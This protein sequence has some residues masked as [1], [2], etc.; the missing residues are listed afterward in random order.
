VVDQDYTHFTLVID[1]SGS[2]HKFR[3]DFQEGVNALVQSQIEQ[4]GRLTV[5]LI[6]FDREVEMLARMVTPDQWQPYTLAP[7]GSTA[8]LDAVGQAIRQT[9]E[10]L[11]AL[12]EGERPGKVLVVIVTDGLENASLKWTKETVREAIQHQRDTYRWEFVFHGA[13]ESAW[14]ARGIGITNS[15]SYAGTREGVIG[16]M[17]AVADSVTSYR[18][19]G[20][21]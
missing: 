8:L 14:A 7:R 3:E 18:A 6:Q 10:D 12:P 19:T 9:G 15:V 13:D 1:R 16:T 20:R 11:A 2:T 5:T 21:L 4:P 17:S